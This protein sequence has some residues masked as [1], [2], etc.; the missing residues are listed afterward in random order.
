MELLPGKECKPWESHSIWPKAI[1]GESI[2][3]H[4]NVLDGGRIGASV[5]P[6]GGKP[7]NS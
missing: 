2:V 7:G 1:R 5:S 6:F 4:K 3:A